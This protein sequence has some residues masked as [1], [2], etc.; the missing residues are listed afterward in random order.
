[1]QTTGVIIPVFNQAIPLLCT[2]HG[3]Q[4]QSVNSFKI[5]IVDDG[6]DEDIR[7]IVRLFEDVLD[8]TYTR[9]NKSGRAIARNVG[10]ETLKG[11]S[12][13]IFCDADR[14]PARNFIQEHL[15][16]HNFKKA[17]LVVGDIKEMYVPDLWNSLPTVFEN[18]LFTKRLRRPQYPRIVYTLFD[19]EGKSISNIPW[20]ATFSGNFSISYDLFN[21]I[22]GFDANFRDW[23]FEHFEFGYRA[24]RQSVDF[25]YNK[26]A[27]NIHIAH[28]RQINYQTHLKKSHDIFKKKHPSPEVEL[29]LDF[30]L[31][32]VSLL[33]LHNVSLPLHDNVPN[34]KNIPDR[35]VKIT[36]F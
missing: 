20:L 32:D 24:Y 28:S 16:A 26:N 8:I 23:G 18:Y 36:N 7:S 3:F 35:F 29:L 5:S 25:L 9:I 12:T 4:K 30:M 19:E 10:V 22:G 33:D 1:M 31:G 15:K 34:F 14:I 13:L 6:S 11:T 17:A 21:K 2:L 27:V